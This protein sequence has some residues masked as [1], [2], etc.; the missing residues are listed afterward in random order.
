MIINW[1][2][3]K[4]GVLIIPCINRNGKVVKH[5]TLLPGHNTVNEKDWEQAKKFCK[6]KLEDGLIEIVMSDKSDIK[7]LKPKRKKDKDSSNEDNVKKSD[8]PAKSIFELS[9]KKAKKIIADTFDLETLGKW[10]E[11][12]GRDEIRALIHKQIE[13][14]ESPPIKD[15]QSNM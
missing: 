6:G 12:E 5:I 3:P 11:E 4:A 10:L 8:T 15:G 9:A 13:F 14:V 1:K 2:K 7:S